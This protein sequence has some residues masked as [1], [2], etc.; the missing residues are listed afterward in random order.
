MILHEE[1]KKQRRAQLQL[2]Q[3]LQEQHILSAAPVHLISHLPGSTNITQEMVASLPSNT[4]MM[5]I[6]AVN[7]IINGSVLLLPFTCICCSL[8]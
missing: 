1:H 7:F 5:R 4:Y 6:M 2:Q 3:L 8:R